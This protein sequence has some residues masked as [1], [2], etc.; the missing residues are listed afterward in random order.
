MIAAALPVLLSQIRVPEQQ[1]NHV[2]GLFI[3]A[4]DTN[5]SQGEWPEV[6]ST[7]SPVTM[8][9]WRVPD[10]LFNVKTPDGDTGHPEELRRSGQGPERSV[11]ARGWE[12]DARARPTARQARFAR[13]QRLCAAEEKAT[14][15]GARPSRN[16]LRMSRKGSSMLCCHL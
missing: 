13:G 7:L 10:V 14:L 1:K 16:S 5:G 12:E 2:S 15:G 4:T 8:L 6:S 9:S 3:S 11:G